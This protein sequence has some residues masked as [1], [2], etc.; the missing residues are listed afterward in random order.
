M[1]DVKTVT[2]RL[3]IEMFVNCPNE[4]C[5]YLIDLLRESDTDGVNHDDDGY[6]LRQMFPT[7][8]SHDDF[9]CEE[10]VCSKC[11]AEFNVKGLEW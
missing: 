3:D 4:E 1:S 8:R 7:N 2:A 10:V 11:K 6:L 5:D 9:E